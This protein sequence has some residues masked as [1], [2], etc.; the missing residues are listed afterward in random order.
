MPD[1]TSTWGQHLYGGNSRIDRKNKPQKTERIGQTN[2]SNQSIFDS[3]FGNQNVPNDPALSKPVTPLSPAAPA[4]AQPRSREKVKA[5]ASNFQPK[6]I[7][8]PV[9]DFKLNGAISTSMGGNTDY[10]SGLTNLAK[11]VNT[12]TAA[13]P[14]RKE[15]RIARRIERL[16]RRQEIQKQKGEL[17]LSEGRTMDAKQKRY[18]YNNLQKRIDRN[19][20]KM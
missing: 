11:S 3:N 10:Q 15:M 16:E 8:N 4:P 9:G 5:I 20:A 17:A 7:E 14:T 13:E 19:K 1:Y 12:K 18:R 6:G 2:T